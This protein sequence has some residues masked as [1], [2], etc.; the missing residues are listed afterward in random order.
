MSMLNWIGGRGENREMG[1]SGPG[2][3]IYRTLGSL[4][5]P[6]PSNT[7]V[8][9]D[10]RE[11]SIND[12][13]F[14]VDMTGYPG[15]GAKYRIVDLPASYHGGAGGLSFADGHSELRSWKDSRTKPQLRPGVIIPYDSP[16]AFNRDIAWLQERATRR[17]N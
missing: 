13:M 11:D 5:D 2:W 14:V 8:F 1:W 3:R 12:G 7:F 15:D 17:E 6:G 9:L 10:E 16:S 4:T